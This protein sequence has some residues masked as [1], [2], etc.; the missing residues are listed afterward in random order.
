MSELERRLKK[1]GTDAPPVIQK[2]LSVARQELAQ[3]KH[4]DYLLISTSIEEDVRRAR[5]ILA[6]E[7]M[8]QARATPPSFD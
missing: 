1:R 3:W 5:A 2:R 7:R 8:K 6:A 4:F